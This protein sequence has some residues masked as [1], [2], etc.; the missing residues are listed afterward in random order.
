[1]LYAFK[2]YYAQNYAGII[3]QG[4][5]QT[6]QSLKFH[7][8]TAH[9]GCESGVGRLDGSPVIHSPS[10]LALGQLVDDWLLYPSLTGL[11]R[12]RWNAKEAI[13]IM[14]NFRPDSSSELLAESSDDM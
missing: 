2:V 9:T 10:S 14:L 13:I 6:I 1:M 8:V 4:L 5:F 3:R 7:S 11:H 12:V